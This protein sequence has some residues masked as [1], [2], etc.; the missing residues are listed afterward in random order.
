VAGVKR[1]V[2]DKAGPGTQSLRCPAC[3]RWLGEVSDYAR[4]VCRGCSA[5]VTYKS[6]AERRRPPA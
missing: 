6:Q 5:E 4:L 3:G 2:A 1:P